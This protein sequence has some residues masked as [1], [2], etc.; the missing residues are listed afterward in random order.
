VATSGEASGVASP[1]STRTRSA[2]LLP[3]TSMWARARAGSLTTFS[4]RSRSASSGFTPLPS[5]LAA[6][7]FSHRRVPVS[8]SA[9]GLAAASVASVAA[10]TPRGTSWP[11]SV[12]QE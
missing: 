5:S 4:T 3:M 2:A 8:V 7:A 1:A 12:S 9:A 11:S 10:T 6:S